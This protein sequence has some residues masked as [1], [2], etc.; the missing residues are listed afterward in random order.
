MFPF[1]PSVVAESVC[2]LCFKSDFG[3]YT[4]LPSIADILS[5]ASQ[6]KLT[7]YFSENLKSL[8]I[9]LLNST[10]GQGIGVP[11]DWDIFFHALLL[12]FF[13]KGINMKCKIL[14]A[15][16]INVFFLSPLSNSSL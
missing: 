3:T 4:N 8:S 5:H 6:S 16:S 7:L 13:V 12:I 9:S 1:M 15:I 2:I 11:K 14:F 10:L